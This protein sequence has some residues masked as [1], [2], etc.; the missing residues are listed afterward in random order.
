MP[1]VRIVVA[2]HEIE[3]KGEEST[4]DLAEIAMDLFKRTTLPASNLRVGFDSTGGTFERE[5][6]DVDPDG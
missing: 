6:L 4:H 5:A 3:V 1:E 2:A